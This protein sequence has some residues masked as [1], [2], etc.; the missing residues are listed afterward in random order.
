M[1]VQMLLVLGCVF[2]IRRI[3][4]HISQSW[5]KPLNILAGMYFSFIFVIYSSFWG[6]RQ[7]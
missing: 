3:P 7:Q 4:L 5:D 2:I 6:R 1:H